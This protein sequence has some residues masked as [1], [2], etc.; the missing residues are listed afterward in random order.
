[1]VILPETAADGA[2]IKANHLLEGFRK[3]RVPFHE[4]IL[5]VTASLG[6]S[7][8]LRTET[9]EDFYA[10]LDQLLYVSKKGG[11]DRISVDEE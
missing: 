4:Q 2:L 11:R 3:N 7:E 6:V 5:A 10:R 8:F 9:L 1:M